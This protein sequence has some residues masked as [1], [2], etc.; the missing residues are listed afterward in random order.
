MKFGRIVRQVN[1]HNQVTE[2]DFSF[3]I[4]RHDGNDYYEPGEI[5][6]IESKGYERV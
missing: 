5:T 2:S 3:L 4:W 1:T 6:I